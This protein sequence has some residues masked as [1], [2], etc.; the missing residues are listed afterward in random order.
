LLTI[1]KNW[2]K[3]W[4]KKTSIMGILNITPDSFSDGGDF[5]DLKNALAQTKKLVLSGVDILDIGA[6]STR[7]GAENISPKEEIK[8]LL[9]ALIEIR[10]N[11]PNLIISIDTFN[12]EVAYQALKNGANWINDVSGGRRDKS[13]LDVV[14]DFDCPFVITH[15]K[16]N[17]KTMDK[18]TFYDDL[19]EEIINCLVKFSEISI[20]RKISKDKIIW[21]PGLGFA[22][23]TDQNISI[24]KNL[25][26]LKSFDYPLLIGASRKRFIGE[27][28]NE[29]NPKNRDIGSLAVSCICA[30]K[31]IEI[32]RV[33]DVNLNYQILKVADKLYR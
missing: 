21:D 19:I 26:R 1:D 15:S 14:A 23:N 9:P 18:L 17:S 20:N 33:H 6:Q 10:N 32:V 4:G 28:L 13:I 7:P 8:R 11:F 3:N 31:N 30:Q 22:K 5:F 29:D 27:I 25:D 24:L 12:S 16:G 2:P